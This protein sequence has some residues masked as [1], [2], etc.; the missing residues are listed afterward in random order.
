[1]RRDKKLPAKTDITHEEGAHRYI[2]K[3]GGGM[4]EEYYKIPSG[5]DNCD[6]VIPEHSILI[7]YKRIETDRL[8]S[9][10][11][12]SCPRVC[13]S[14]SQC[15]HILENI[16]KK[17]FRDR[18][19]KAARQLKETQEWIGSAES[20]EGWFSV[21]M[22]TNS[23]DL[24]DSKMS[25]KVIQE[26]MRVLMANRRNDGAVHTAIDAV[27]FTCFEGDTTVIID[28]RFEPPL[29]SYPFQLYHRDD[30]VLRSRRMHC[31]DVLKEGYRDYLKEKTGATP[32]FISSQF[33]ESE[34]ISCS[35]DSI[36]EKPPCLMFP[37][38]EEDP[39]VILSTPAVLLEKGS[40]LKESKCLSREELS[41]SIDA[42]ESLISPYPPEDG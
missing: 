10:I 20:G 38:K 41:V 1:M 19:S 35:K 21:L 22:L 4:L 26:M 6:F 8:I 12:K 32:V 25:Y 16:Y 37:G 39:I 34:R 29:R 11:Q 17:A 2:E 42:R 30:L 24:G 7:E 33:M 13:A 18:V 9:D 15:Q 27:L 23:E 5:K 14:E 28:D 31:Y 36:K 3:C 40:R